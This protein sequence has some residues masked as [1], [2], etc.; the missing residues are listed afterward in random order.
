MEVE[1]LGKLDQIVVGTKQTKRHLLKSKVDKVYIAQ[2]A[3]KNV[4]EEIIDMCNEKKIE[5]I[6]IDRMKELGR[7]CNIDVNAA[8]VAVLK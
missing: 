7:M 2:D 3:E 8:V 4:T 6:Y 1:Q 5:I